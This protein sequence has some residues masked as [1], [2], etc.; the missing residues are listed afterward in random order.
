MLKVYKSIPELA[1][2]AL[3]E[4]DIWVNM[5]NPMPAEL[6]QVTNVL[7]IS[8]AF[9]EAVLDNDER[10]HIDLLDGQALI[11]I[12]V[13]ILR[14][15][16]EPDEEHNLLYDTIPL[17]IILCPGAVITVCLE[18]APG[19]SRLIARKIPDVATE[20]HM[21]LVAR[22]LLSTASQYLTHLRQIGSRANELERRVL[23]ATSNAQVVELLSL[24]K[25]LTYFLSACRANEAVM[26]QLQRA[27]EFPALAT[28]LSD[29]EL[30]Q[31]LIETAI[32]ENKQAI[33][34]CEVYREVLTSMMSAFS[35]LTSNNLNIAMRFLTSVTIVLALPTLVSSI[36]G[37]N[38]NL[39]FQQSPNA[40]AIVSLISIFSTIASAVYLVRKGMF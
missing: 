26:R 23:R 11:A 37:M 19:L 40:F 10:S 25:S 5:V 7:G 20:H 16:E 4:P 15:S 34:M 31:P 32:I 29:I 36:Y 24:E 22:L 39:P 17:G 27:N 21:G 13:P 1:P 2:A 8:P 9:L 28:L 6:E 14:E 35:S 38:V 12:N 33:A 18:E 30:S 3:S